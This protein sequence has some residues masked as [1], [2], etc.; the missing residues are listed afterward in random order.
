MEKQR[1]ELDSQGNVKRKF[2]HEWDAS[3][4]INMNKIPDLITSIVQQRENMI[5]YI[6]ELHD[7]IDYM[8]EHNE[9]CH[10]ESCLTAGC[11][12]DHK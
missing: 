6:E 10:A 7:K 5:E 1:F 11:T 12:S 4:L 2:G 3:G 8:I 9:M